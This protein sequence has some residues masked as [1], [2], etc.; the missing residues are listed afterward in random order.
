MH[1]ISK[2]VV[3]VDLHEGDRLV[4]DTLPE[5]TLAAVKQSLDFAVRRSAH[6]IYC[7]ALNLSPQ[8]EQ[9]IH[10]DVTNIFVTVEDHARKI[11]TKLVEEAA[12]AG[13]KATF[14][15]RF[16]AAWRELA[17]F[18][19]EIRADLLVVGARNR[20]L[21]SHTLFGSTSTKLMQTCPCA[22]WVVK[23]EELREIRELAV[24]TDLSEDSLR[25]MHAAIAFAQHLDARLFILH[26]VEFPL[27]SYLRSA[28]SDQAAID[29]YHKKVLSTAHDT[30]HSQLHQTDWRTLSHGVRVELLEGSPESTI[31]RFVEEN[32]VDL[33]V[34]TTHGRTGLSQFVMGSTA[35]HLLPLLKSSV[36]AL[37]PAE[38]VSPVEI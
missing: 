8:A 13:V 4:G 36:M 3:G 2:I 23:P 11:L 1:T 15:L 34:L 37:K 10:G 32:G 21:L 33:V 19:Q 26:A 27:A 24:C 16:G 9:L 7:A 18:V 28:G 29:E 14:E 20:S 6:I 38:F 25:A 12:E 30:I 22:V 17:E 31:P 5:T 35:Q